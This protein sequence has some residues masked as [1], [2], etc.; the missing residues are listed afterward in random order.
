[1]QSLQTSSPQF[2][3]SSLQALYSRLQAESE[4]R[5]SRT[6]LLRYEP[7]PKQAAFH[8]AGAMHRERLLMAANQSGKTHA[9]AAEAAFHLTGNYP[10]WWIGRRCGIA[11]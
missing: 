10:D 4:R 6:K 8:A 9:G 2:N 7:Y 3:P 5:L 11:L 1:M